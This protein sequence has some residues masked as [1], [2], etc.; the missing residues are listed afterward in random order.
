MTDAS[1]LKYTFLATMISEDVWLC[2]PVLVR[3]VAIVVLFVHILCADTKWLF[4]FWSAP[5]VCHYSADYWPGM[6][7]PANLLVRVNVKT[8]RKDLSIFRSSCLNVPLWYHIWDFHALF[9]A[10]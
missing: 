2:V 8:E 7:T 4:L 10:M 3:A 5:M 6:H 9:L 1:L